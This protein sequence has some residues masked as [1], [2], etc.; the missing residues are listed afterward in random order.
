MERI[1]CD[2]S[3]ELTPAALAKVLLPRSRET[4]S[5]LEIVT[6]GCQGQDLLQNEL[7]PLCQAADVFD[8]PKISPGNSKDDSSALLTRGQ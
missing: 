7:S 4:T 6:W 2:P 8:K 3:P 1:H 5:H